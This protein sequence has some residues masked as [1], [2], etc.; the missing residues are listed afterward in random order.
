M[1]T[2][3]ERMRGALIGQF[4]GDAACLGSHWIYDL[5]EIDRR[6]PDGIRGFEPPAEGDYHYGKRP[7]DLTHYGDAALLMLESVAAFGRFDAVDFGRRFVGLFGSDSYTG[8]RDHATRETLAAY[9]AHVGEHPAKQFPYQSGADDDQPATVT[10]LVPLVI[11]HRDDPGLP[12]VVAAATRVCQNN[13]RAVSY[14]QCHAQVL[15]QL[16]AGKGLVEA[17]EL[18]A[19]EVG[20][21]PGRKIGEALALRHLE[22]REATLRFGQSC[23]LAGSFPAAVQAA[24][25]HGDSF[26]GALLATAR[27][28]G[29]NAGRAAL[30]GAWLGAALGESGVPAEWRDRLTVRETVIRL[31]DLLLAI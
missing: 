18:A 31:G 10:R 2:R 5:A 23:P 29:D 6:F 27:A 25:R 11:A 24:V 26:A 15:R 13:D 8:Y 28:G 17:M 19:E 22:V 21:E 3:E 12:E 1:A 4:V 7:G 16:F 30:V 9:H 14:A 20:G